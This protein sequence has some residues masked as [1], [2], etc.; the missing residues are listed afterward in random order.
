MITQHQVGNYRIDLSFPQHKL[1]I[2]C[3][4]GGHGDRV[5]EQ[6]V[7]RQK[8]PGRELSRK[9]IRYNPDAQNNELS[10]VINQILRHLEICLQADLM[11][12]I[13]V[14]YTAMDFDSL[15]DSH[16]KS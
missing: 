5:L 11:L 1:T 16:W 14:L 2:E 9:L 10:R 7:K 6:E 3:N 8:F 15:V 4:E 13:Y 12:T